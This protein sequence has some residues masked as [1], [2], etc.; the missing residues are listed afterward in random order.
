MIYIIRTLEILFLNWLQHAKPLWNPSS[1]GIQIIT[2]HTL[3][4]GDNAQQNIES[5][6]TNQLAMLVECFF[7]IVIQIPGIMMIVILFNGRCLG[8]QI[9]VLILQV[10]PPAPLLVLVSTFNA[11]QNHA[12]FNNWR[13]VGRE[14][15]GP[16]TTICHRFPESGL[17]V[18]R[19]IMTVAA[20]IAHLG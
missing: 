1:I 20:R 13:D 8:T 12:M 15:Q 5:I 3:T 7:R 14:K 4:R 16:K 18:I 10:I 9:L 2:M 19:Q 11:G 17:V 6:F